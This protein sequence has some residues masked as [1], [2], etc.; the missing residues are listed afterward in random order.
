MIKY[1]H[2]VIKF[3]R[4]H[5]DAKLPARGSEWAAG[6]DLYSVE[7]VSI[8]PGARSTVRT[9]VSAAIPDGYYGRIAPRS[10][11]AV[12]YGLDVLAGVIDCDYRG[13]IIC[14]LVNLGNEPVRLERGERIAQLIIEAIIMPTPEWA[15]EL[16]DTKRGAAGFGSTDKDDG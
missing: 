4:L 16:N 8:I 15:D 5:P 12:N 2:Q 13:E 3:S 7:A 1:R 14:L 11:L 9:G 10:G 6:L